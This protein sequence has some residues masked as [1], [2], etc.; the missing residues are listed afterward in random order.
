[1][2]RPK[3]FQQLVEDLAAEDPYKAR[4]CAEAEAVTWEDPDPNGPAPGTAAFYQA[5]WHRAQLYL[6]APTPAENTPAPVEEP[7]VPV[8]DPNA[9]QGYEHP[10]FPTSTADT[11]EEQNES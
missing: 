7:Q 3:S 9:D 8:I 4:V 10:E 6:Q 1:M 5:V 11:F 2:P